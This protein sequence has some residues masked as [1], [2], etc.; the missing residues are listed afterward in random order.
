LGQLVDV[1]V[2]G[3]EV[4]PGVA[5]VVGLRPEEEL[6]SGGSQLGGRV[7]DVVDQEPDDRP[8][9]KWRLN[10][11][12]GLKT[13]TL[14][15]SGSCSIQNPERSDSRRRPKTSRKKATVDSAWSVRV[16]THAN[17]MIR[18]CPTAIRHLA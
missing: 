12:S 7:L 11:L 14:L 16:P 17:L 5:A 13:S 9:V 18:I 3:A 15:P 10:G 4:H 6:G 2:R 1:A 8:V